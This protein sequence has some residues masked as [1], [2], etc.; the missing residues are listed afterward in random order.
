MASI[1]TTE[2]PVTSRLAPFEGFP[3]W[4]FST[5]IWNP[6]GTSTF[7]NAFYPEVPATQP[8]QWWRRKA[9]WI[10]RAKPADGYQMTA[11]DGSKWVYPANDDGRMRCYAAGSTFSRGDQRYRGQIVT[12]PNDLWI[13]D[14]PDWD[15][16]PITAGSDVVVGDTIRTLATFAGTVANATESITDTLRTVTFRD[17]SFVVLGFYTEYWGPQQVNYLDVWTFFQRLAKPSVESK[18]SAPDGSRWVSA[19]NSLFYCWAF[20]ANYKPGAL[21]LRGEIDGGLTPIT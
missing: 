6:D 13:C 16:M 12:D 10:R 15:W 14:D 18:F 17:S 4:M 11:P 1:R 2:G 9:V 20:G 21:L 8:S 5:L 3:W 7:G 19:G